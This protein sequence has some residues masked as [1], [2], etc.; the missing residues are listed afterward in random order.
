[1]NKIFELLGNNYK[2]YTESIES[3]IF[4]DD[5]KWCF[6]FSEGGEEYIEILIGEKISDDY[7][8]LVDFIIDTLN[9]KRVKPDEFSKNFDEI[10]MKNM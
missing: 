5:D 1:M 8:N 2:K 9:N 4:Y 6:P 3:L 7:R 10:I